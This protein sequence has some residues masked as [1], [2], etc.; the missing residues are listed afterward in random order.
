[1]EKGT[2]APSVC[3]KG[4][5][6]AIREWGQQGVNRQFR[7]LQL[8][9]EG[10]DAMRR[11]G[12]AVGLAPIAPIHG[13]MGPGRW[14]QRQAQPFPRLQGGGQGLQL[15]MALQRL[16]GLTAQHPPHPCAELPCG[17]GVCAHHGQG[18]TEIKAR[19]IGLHPQPQDGATQKLQRDLEGGR[20]E[21]GHI[22]AS[23]EIRAISKAG[24]SP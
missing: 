4:R 24:L 8:Q 13:Q 16:C 14:G 11:C 15:H 18:S 21:T 5:H 17:L 12:P 22:A 3:C 7:T 19:L 1:M 10:D 6:L 23:I 2:R 20:G 9:G